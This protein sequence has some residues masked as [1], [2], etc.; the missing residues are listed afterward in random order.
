MVVQRHVTH[1]RLL[2]ILTAGESMRFEHISNTLIESLNYAIGS[3]RSW[4]SWAAFNAQGLAQLANNLLVNFLLLSVR[5]FC[6]LIGQALCRAIIMTSL[7]VGR[8]NG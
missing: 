1:E 2:Q 6:I 7:S 8:L 5:I 3:G 4:F